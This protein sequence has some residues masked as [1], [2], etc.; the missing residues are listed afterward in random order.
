MPYLPGNAFP[1]AE[2]VPAAT[3]NSAVAAHPCGGGMCGYTLAALGGA[4]AH[5]L[6][7]GL[8]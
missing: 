8:L 7:T 5:H 4:L 2:L 1:E 3:A 6:T